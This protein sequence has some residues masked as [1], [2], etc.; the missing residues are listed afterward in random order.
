MDTA[1]Y[2]FVIARCPDFIDRRPEGL[3]CILVHYTY[4]CPHD[5]LHVISPPGRT[6]FVGG[7]ICQPA[8]GG[9]WEDK[10]AEGSLETISVS[11]G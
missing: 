10:E 5:I 8:R 4:S 6:C 3:H 2:V 9:Y 11:K 7:E 1:L